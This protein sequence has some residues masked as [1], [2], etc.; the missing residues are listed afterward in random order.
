MGGTFTRG[1][2]VATRHPMGS[3]YLWFHTELDDTWDTL[4]PHFLTHHFPRKS[5]DAVTYRSASSH[6]ATL[7]L[8]SRRVNVRLSHEAQN[9]NQFSGLL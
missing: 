3:I 2:R 5:N 4:I 6:F 1:V 7:S 9:P 8:L